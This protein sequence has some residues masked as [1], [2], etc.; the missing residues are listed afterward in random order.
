MWKTAAL[1]RVLTSASGEC[2]AVYQQPHTAGTCRTVSVLSYTP[3]PLSV[4]A[5]NASMKTWVGRL[6]AVLTTRRPGF[7]PRSVHVRFVV[8]RMGLDRLISKY[9]GFPLSVS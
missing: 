9:F 1:S 8:D 7:D 2:W 3:S 5:I 4:V 6:V